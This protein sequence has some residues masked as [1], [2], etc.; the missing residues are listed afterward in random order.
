MP[1]EAD[2]NDDWLIGQFGARPLDRAPIA[3]LDDAEHGRAEA[4]WREHWNEIEE[5][6]KECQRKRSLFFLNELTA[7]AIHPVAYALPLNGRLGFKLSEGATTFNDPDTDPLKRESSLA[8]TAK[9]MKAAP[10]DEL[11]KSLGHAEYAISPLKEGTSQV[12]S[13]HL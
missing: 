13:N 6:L 4:I 7:L 9:E 12:L 1:I 3:A 8:K 5:L 10:A 11:R 2:D